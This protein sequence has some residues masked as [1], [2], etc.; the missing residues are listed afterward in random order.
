MHLHSVSLKV[1]PHVAVFLRNRFPDGVTVSS[2]DRYGKTLLHLAQATALNKTRDLPARYRDTIRVL[3]PTGMI[4][5]YGSRSFSNYAIVQFS[6][7]VDDDM[8]QELF[9]RIQSAAIYTNAQIKDVVISWMEELGISEVSTY[10]KW[11]RAYYRAKENCAQ[12]S[13]I[14]HNCHHAH[15]QAQR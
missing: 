14:M 1:L 6:E 5:R 4:F 12:S 2:R 8:Q 15:S 11:I 13:R 9:T 3:C 7:L 10:D